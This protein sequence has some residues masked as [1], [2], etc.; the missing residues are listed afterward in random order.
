MSAP[1]QLT[2]DRAGPSLVEVSSSVT[3]GGQD[4]QPRGVAPAAGILVG[5]LLAVT[6]AVARP[7]VA[8]LGCLIF[9]W[10]VAPGVLVVR[11]AVGRAPGW[12]TACV[13]GPIV[14]FG[15]SS[16]VLL[17]LWWAGARG[18][19]SVGIAPVLA[20]LTF[21][22]A[23][24]LNSRLALA[25]LD[26]RDLRA[27]CLVALIVPFVV[28]VP[29]ARVG[30][31][32]PEGKAYRAYFTAD[33]VWRMTV[34]A[35]LAKGDMP[36]K[37]PFFRND[38]LHYYW[39]PH[40]LSG[41][42]YRNLR[43][44]ATLDELL[45]LQSL[46]MDVAFVGWLYGLTRQFVQSRVAAGFGIA[47]VVLFTS[48][49]G[50]YLVA[51]F[52]S[53]GHPLAAVRGYNV[54]AVNRWLLGGMPIDGLQ[55]L[56][57]YQP[58][59][60]CGYALGVLA[61]L[62]AGR[63]TRPR[64]WRVMLAAGVLLGLSALIST[65]GALMLASAVG[66]YELVGAARQRDLRRLVSHALMATAPFAAAYGL[67]RA[68]QYAEVAAGPLLQI[69][70]NPQAVSNAWVSIF[71]SLGPVLLAG[72]AGA[73]VALWRR[74]GAFVVLMP[75]VGVVV[76]FYFFVDVVDHQHVYVGWRCGHLLLIA[77]APVIGLAVEA[78]PSLHR[79]PR[80]VGMA[81]LAA[82]ATLAA[83]M[84]A[85]DLWNS[86]DVSNRAD[87]PSFRWTLVITHAELA[88]LNWI[89]ANTPPDAIVQVDPTAR[90]ADTW[91][92][93]PAFAE[94]RMAIGLPISMIPRGKYVHGSNE[95]HAIFAA[96]TP[97]EAHERAVRFGIDYLLV[98]PPELKAC[99]DVDLRLETGP[100]YFTRVVRTR[101]VFVFR[102]NPVPVAARAAP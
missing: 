56:L 1:R 48:F 30:S 75:L 3:P 50:T 82:L 4:R 72:I 59:H 100:Q 65:F 54:D 11:A 77:L 92:Y 35:E 9:A 15:L 61:L 86:Q 33:Y 74:T 90:D 89:K 13:F 63:R 88:V 12:L 41:V 67:I 98:G 46:L 31:W 27:F 10:F 91:A 55:R 49:E 57:M 64:D 29:F 79:G 66:L 68:L 83:P 24:G 51:R 22:P 23:R 80:V 99:P 47:A 69:G 36:P 37:N 45:L 96:S 32:V 84:T 94:R 93:V 71:V 26:R 28:G 17:A 53:E 40:L 97:R 34:V 16:V 43:Q 62:V 19:W 52:W 78:L 60:A 87:G 101:S 20:A 95:M 81:A 102:V 58:H 21:Y 18:L 14:G 42:Q 39:L 8:A 7:G 85:I 70:V 73:A 38:A 76:F 6:F 5:A 2:D 25:R 44:T